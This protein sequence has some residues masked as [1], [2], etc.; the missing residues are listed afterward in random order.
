M[1]EI[2]VTTYILHPCN[3]FLGNVHIGNRVFPTTLRH[4]SSDSDATTGNFHGVPGIF[5]ETPKKKIK[6]KIWPLRYKLIT[7]IPLLN[8]KITPHDKVLFTS[9]EMP[10]GDYYPE[11]PSL[12]RIQHGKIF[13]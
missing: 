13:S 11:Y 6:I 9:K 4:V 1:K 12:F 8:E 2:Q 7:E 3:I 10:D 5:F